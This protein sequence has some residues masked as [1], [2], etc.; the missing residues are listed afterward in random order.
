[1]LFFARLLQLLGLIEAGYGLFI[2]VYENDIKR[3]LTFAAFGTFLFLVGW[4]LQ[5][6]ASQ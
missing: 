6:R 4:W 5:K 1:M 3:E 2:G